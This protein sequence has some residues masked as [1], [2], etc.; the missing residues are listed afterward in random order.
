MSK[1][2]LIILYSYH[3][4]NTEKVAKV[5]AEV[6]N[7]S[8]KYPAQIDVNALKYYDLIGFGSGIYGGK[9]HKSILKL[10]KQLRSVDKTKAFI[11]S[12]DG[13]PRGLMKFDSKLKNQSFQNHDKLRNLLNKKG[14]EI[15]NEFNCG[16]YNTNSFLKVFGGI[17]KGR[18][19]SVDL[20]R[21]KEF[22]IKLE[23]EIII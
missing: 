16:G 15:V 21:A 22:A 6:L 2:T 3:H 17:N 18:P 13:T 4:K 14:F 9:H 8:I 1:K 5:M 20:K 19:N 12:T 11:F 10:V 7:A 23:K